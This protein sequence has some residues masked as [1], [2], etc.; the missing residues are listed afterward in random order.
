[1]LAVK[2][3]EVVNRLKKSGEQEDKRQE[4]FEGMK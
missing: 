3:S 4:V 1:V 2:Y